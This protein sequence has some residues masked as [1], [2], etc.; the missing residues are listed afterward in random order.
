MVSVGVRVSVAVM[1]GDGSGVCVAVGLLSVAV[2]EGKGEAVRVGLAVSDVSKGA[3][4][5][6]PWQA[7]SSRRVIVKRIK[8]RDRM[9]VLLRMVVVSN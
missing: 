4:L 8:K 5:S 1:V 3:P 7:V 2:A 9:A 6:A